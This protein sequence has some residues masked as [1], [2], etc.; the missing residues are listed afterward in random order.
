MRLTARQ[1]RPS[2]KLRRQPQARKR[3]NEAEAVMAGPRLRVPNTARQRRRRNQRQR[4]Q[5]KFPTA[6]LKRLVL[7]PRWISLFLLVATIA[8]LAL[9]GLDEAFYLTLIPVEGVVSI[10]P[11]EIVGVSGL[12][13]AHTFSIDPE[14]AANSIT[15]IPGVI[16]STVTMRWPNQVHIRILEDTPIAVWE[17]AG[18]QY[19]ING[20]GQI[21][22]A[23][24]AV[25][26]LL[27]IVLLGSEPSTTDVGADDLIEETE[28]LV[29]VPDEVLA[30]ALQ[31]RELRPTLDTVYYQ[32]SGGL[33]FED[34]R[35]WQAFFGSGT[36]MTQK[37]VVYEAIA[38]DLLAR[39]LTPTE[40]SVA[41]QE[42]PYY[43][44]T[45]P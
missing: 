6:A 5:L 13:G 35:G 42:K 20:T 34:G 31:L 9:I 44:A 15:D 30:G 40:I 22:P 36:D 25:S 3:R 43:R 33:N 39:G 23:R 10:P 11:E 12:A 27:H 45:S 16:S 28:T 37:L 38:E 18:Q 26:G 24:L 1:Q 17:Q 7:S 32:P 2:R 19:W 29:F 4:L 41:S 14:Q 21:L 8:S